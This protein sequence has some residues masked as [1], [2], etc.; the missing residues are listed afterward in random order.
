MFQNLPVF[1]NSD[2]KVGEIE[3]LCRSWL[4]FGIFF[5]FSFSN[6]AE[7]EQYKTFDGEVP[8]LVV[9]SLQD[10]LLPSFDI[11]DETPANFLNVCVGFLALRSL[12]VLKEEFKKCEEWRQRDADMNTAHSALKHLEQSHA[13]LTVPAS[14][15]SDDYDFSA[16]LNLADE[17]VVQARDQ[18]LASI[19]KNVELACGAVGQNLTM[20]PLAT[21]RAELAREPLVKKRARALLL[22]CTDPHVAVFKE[23]V[24]AAKAA[25][26]RCSEIGNSQLFAHASEKS[27]EAFRSIV[28]GC[29]EVMQKCD[30][31]CAIL[32]SVIALW[33]DLAPSEFRA[34]VVTEA[35]KQIHF[36]PEMPDEL[37]LPA[38]LA[39]LMKAGMEG[40]S[41]HIPK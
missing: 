11:Q 33:R 14:W 25:Q 15:K 13:R 17:G 28:T 20:E 16:V 2:E 41:T 36:P 35:Q 7:I 5:S 38:C 10:S 32:T 6:V 27:R 9:G 34:T 37:K 18:V 29:E 19:A 39:S 23:S 22:K 40:R 4:E 12:G 31:M 1:E 8:E 3:K 26:E 30:S 24:H 21:Y